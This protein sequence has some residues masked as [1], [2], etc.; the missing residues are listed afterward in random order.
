MDL[1]ANFDDELRR[2]MPQQES[3]APQNADAT[4][5]LHL[6]DQNSKDKQSG[7]LFSNAGA[8][9]H[10]RENAQKAAEN[11]RETQKVKLRTY[12]IVSERITSETGMLTG[13]D[14]TIRRRST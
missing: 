1:T 11:Y 7:M 4:P 13:L 12:R 14:R 9:V 10:F 2:H 3:L 6:K 5:S 8:L